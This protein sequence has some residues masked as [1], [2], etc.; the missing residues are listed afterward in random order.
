MFNQPPIHLRR[1]P[2][3]IS[4]FSSFVCKS[5]VFLCQR[6]MVIVAYYLKPSWGTLLLNAF[7]NQNVLLVCSASLLK[8]GNVIALA[9]PFHAFPTLCSSKDLNGRS[10]N[11]TEN[12]CRILRIWFFHFWGRYFFILF[13]WYPSDSLSLLEDYWWEFPSCS[14][15]VY[16]DLLL[17]DGSAYG[18]FFINVPWVLEKPPMVVERSALCY[19]SGLL[20]CFRS[21]SSIKFLVSEIC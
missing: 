9:W 14:F 12:A 18:L 6:L 17:L 16:C 15:E 13:S 1:H 5:R 8:W 3:C 7:W 2:D 4:P 11:R 21:W 19:W 10:W 20:C